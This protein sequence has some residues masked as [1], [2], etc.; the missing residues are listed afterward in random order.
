MCSLS[1]KCSI[2]SRQTDRADPNDYQVSSAGRLGVSIERDGVVTFGPIVV[3][4]M[5]I[6]AWEDGKRQGYK[7]A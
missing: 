4:V 2:S 3:D 7:P 6:S 1:E 5:A